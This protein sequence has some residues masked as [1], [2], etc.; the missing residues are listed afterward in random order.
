VAII[1]LSVYM[2]VGPW[3]SKALYVSAPH[4]VPSVT[5]VVAVLS[6]GYEPWLKK[7]LSIDRPKQLSSDIRYH[8]ALR[9]VIIG[10]YS[11]LY[12]VFESKKKS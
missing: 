9:L 2:G 6:I 8:V 7:Q 1:S 5:T 4:F 10:H 11:K 3:T 12:F